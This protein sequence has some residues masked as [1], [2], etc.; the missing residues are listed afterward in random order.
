MEVQQQQQLSREL[1]NPGSCTL[2]PQLV[3][4]S[5]AVRSMLLLASFLHPTK[6][7]DLEVHPHHSRNQIEL[8]VCKFK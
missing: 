8:A 3:C 6:G 2:D 5:V 1:I 7:S 4:G